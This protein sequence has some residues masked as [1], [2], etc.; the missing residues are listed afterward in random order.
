[1]AGLEIKLV[2][3]HERLPRGAGATQKAFT[4][5]TRRSL[6]SVVDNFRSAINQLEDNSVA[7]VHRAIMPTFGL[8]QVYCPIKTGK[9]LDSGKVEVH[10]AKKHR[11]RAKISYGGNGSVPYAAIV[12]EDVTKYHEPPTRSKFLQAAI[13]ETYKEV[14]ETFTQYTKQLIGGKRRG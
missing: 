12:H 2:I 10:Y 1:M 3:G 8:S 13:E 7:N 11:I 4:Q 6:K 9:L 5:S 14:W